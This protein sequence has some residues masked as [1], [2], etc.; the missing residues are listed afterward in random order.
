VLPQLSAGLPGGADRVCYPL[1]AN[2]WQPVSAGAVRGLLL[3]EP[4]PD[5]RV[6]APVVGPVGPALAVLA[7]R[8]L[9]ITQLAGIDPSL[10]W[11]EAAAPMPTRLYPARS[12][13]TAV[14]AAHRGL[15]AELIAIAEE[16]MR[17][18]VEHTS[19]RR[20]FGVPIASFQAV[21]HRL[22]DS[23]TALSA[24]RALLDAALDAAPGEAGR[25]AALAA[26]AQ[27]GRAHQLVSASAIQVCG[28]IGATGEHS[29][30]RYVERGFALDA[31]L[32]DTTELAAQLGAEI[33]ST[34]D[35]PRL[36]GV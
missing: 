20:Q 32:G 33:Y 18:A 6:V 9:S 4:T 25:V 26:K 28:A 17:L 12:W 23:E 3:R 16:A 31:L 27:A 22:A 15:S 19:A 8:E 7:G 1:P 10:S 2:G 30:H 5:A 36:A 29:L 24:A 13:E 21:R 14:A 35:I 34:G 11:V